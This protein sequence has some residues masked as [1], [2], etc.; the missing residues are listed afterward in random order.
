MARTRCP[1]AT[2]PTAC[3]KPRMLIAKVSEAF[4]AD[5]LDRSDAARDILSLNATLERRTAQLEVALANLQAQ[6]S[7]R[8]QAEAALRES[9]QRYR[10]LVELS[11]ES[12]LVMVEDRLVY[13]NAAGVRLL[14]GADVHELV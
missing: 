10:R 14:H 1:R 6:N 11:P 13:I 5:F 9:E 2:S 8:T 3:S 7:Q 4:Y 12:I